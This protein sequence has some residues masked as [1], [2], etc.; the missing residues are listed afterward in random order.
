MHRNVKWDENKIRAWRYR[1]DTG[2][3]F[4][5]S[6]V[7][8]EVKDEVVHWIEKNIGGKVRGHKITQPDP[9][10]SS[11]RA[12]HGNDSVQE[13]FGS[14]IPEDDRL[15][16]KNEDNSTRR[17][18]IRSKDAPKTPKMTDEVV[19][20]VPKFDKPQKGNCLTEG[21]IKESKFRGEWWFEDGQA[22]YADGDVGDTNHEG[23]VINI[24]KMQIVDE[25]GGDTSNDVEYAGEFDDY[26]DEIFEHIGGEFTPEELEDWKEGKYFDAIKSYIVRAGSMELKEKFLYAFSSN[27]DAR[28]YAL[29]YWGWQRVKG[30][31]IQTWTLT[32]Q[33][34]KNITSGLYEAYDEELNEPDAVFFIEVMTTRSFYEDVPWRV[35]QKDNPTALNAYRTRY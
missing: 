32:T 25:L 29:K 5:W 22:I 33:D 7:S 6:S 30:N 34:L 35:L 20:A 12:A 19:I 8:D 21:I 10:L 16:I 17:W 26:A 1:K 13:G 3:V 9:K 15:K 28:E 4:W 24:L 11:F 2:I 23:R 31:V 18:Q 27:K 14:G